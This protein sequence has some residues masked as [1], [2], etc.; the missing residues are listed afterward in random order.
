MTPHEKGNL[1]PSFFMDVDPVHGVHRPNHGLANALR[2]AVLVPLVTEAFK[3]SFQG[4]EHGSFALSANE[5]LGMQ[6]AMLFEVCGRDSDIGFSDSPQVFLGYH[7][8][9]VAAFD[10]YALE[11]GLGAEVSEKCHDALERMYMESKTSASRPFKHVAEKCHDLDLFRCYGGF[12][13]N[14]KLGQLER[15]IGAEATNRLAR[16][17]VV[18]IVATGDRLLFSPFSNIG[19]RSYN[20][21][22]F[23]VCSMPAGCFH[24]LQLMLAE[25]EVTVAQLPLVDGEHATRFIGSAFKRLHAAQMSKWKH[26]QWNSKAIAEQRTAVLDALRKLLKV[27]CKSKNNGTEDDKDDCVLRGNDAYRTLKDKA[28]Y[29]DEYVE[30]MAVRLWTSGEVKIERDGSVRELCSILNET[31]RNDASGGTSYDEGSVEATAILGAAVTVVCMIQHHLNAGRRSGLSQP[32]FWPGGT[33]GS[34]ENKSTEEHTVYRGG[35]LPEEHLRFF[36]RVLAASDPLY[37]VPGLLAT[38]FQRGVAIRFMG[39]SGAL[40]KVLWE[41]KLKDPDDFGGGCKQVNFLEKTAYGGEKEVG[42]LTCFPYDTADL[43]PPVFP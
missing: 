43:P 38:S 12:R 33:S 11:T 34:G 23:P 3:S 27:Y 31:I 15:E 6:I 26:T 21:A 8:K 41:I 24:A 10:K 28:D 20:P 7:V 30:D 1:D 14:E 37:R 39:R 2:K 4:S 18:N 42:V 29:A 5:V 35:G 32:S 17:A 13:M 22:E 16:T 40:P 25:P 19:T 9:S 36:E